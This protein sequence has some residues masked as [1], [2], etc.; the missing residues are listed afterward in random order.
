M[1]N[2]ASR[3]PIFFYTMVTLLIVIAAI[4]GL[5]VLVS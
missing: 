5:A 3:S 2:D 1:A 4:V